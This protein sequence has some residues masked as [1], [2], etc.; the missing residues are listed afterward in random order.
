MKKKKKSAGAGKNYPKNKQKRHFSS[1]QIANQIMHLLDL[2]PG[3]TYTVKQIQQ[4]L[5]AR[6]KRDKNDVEDTLYMLVKQGK[7]D[8][9]RKHFQSKTASE[10]VIGRV[11]HVS[12]HFAF[13]I[14][15]NDDQKDIMIRTPDLNG[16]IDSDRVKV[17]VFPGAKGRD[18]RKAGEVHEVLER[19]HKEIVG[20]LE[21]SENYGFV[22]PNNRKL[23]DDIFIP[24]NKLGNAQD[25]DLVI[26]EVTRWPDAG[27]KNPEGKIIKIL[28]QV[29][30]NDAEMHAIMLEFGLP[31]EF[32]Q[33][34]M[35]AAEAIPDQI[36][37]SEIKKRKDFRNTTT[38]TIDPEDAKDFD[39]ALSIREL[40][41]GNYEIGIHIADVTYYLKEGSILD[42][43]A[44]KRATSVYLV[45]RT[46]PMLPEK[47][48]N[49]LCSL[50]PNED[51]L[52]FSAVFE[53]DKNAKI[54]KQWFGRGIIHSD[55]RFTYEEAQ[56]LIE[57]KKGD[58]S[59][60]VGTLNEI[61][62]VLRKNRFKNGSIAFE[63]T[64]L[65]FLL[66]EDGK[67]LGLTPKVR[68]EAHKMIEDFMLLANK[69]VAE[70]VYGLHGS[71]GQH[72]F[73]YRTHDYPDQEK[74]MNFALFAK[75]FGH[76]I[77]VEGRGLS[78]SINKLS[79]EIE[80][81][82]EQ[83]ILQSLA[84]RAMAK[85]VYTTAPNGHFGLAFQHYTHFT[86]PIRRYPDVMVHRL[87]DKYLNKGQSEG[88]AAY[89]KKCEH[90]SAM[91][92]LAADAERASIKYKQIEWM[93]EMVGQE[94]DAIVSGMNDF[95]IY[96]E[97]I[98]TKCEGMVRMRDI[99]GDFFELQSEKFRIVGQ[100]TGKIIKFGDKLRVQVKSTDINRR[101][102]DLIIV[103][104]AD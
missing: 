93:Q 85:A 9:F 79:E 35:Q 103:D 25:D 46:V 2:H 27:E 32:P 39:D 61:S 83:N 81:K 54:H 76:T 20:S 92:K 42:K 89:E 94:F 11:D 62:L 104:N 90:S 82:P 52:V 23:Y 6:N 13:V 15:E 59:S 77:D 47:L 4:H 18:G 80:G 29:G 72:T 60:E 19:K 14:P 12:P 99:E 33:D 64:E 73:V 50:R 48:S 36:P 95:G 101:T 74:L 84:I 66:D 100:R 31:Y 91:E 40:E 97:I 65:K 57:G 3:R 63:S 88:R 10:T 55:R 98:D 51:R 70:Y 38:F 75:N 69:K 1:S 7:V 34:V 56:E 44:Y 86:S 102:M 17:V 28:G 30:D 5:Y 78:K 43:E 24:G 45:D 41:N 53:M 68:K 16:A 87:L 8:Q 21:M 37:A 96:M 22:V 49:N 58:F 26:A 67:P 71:Q